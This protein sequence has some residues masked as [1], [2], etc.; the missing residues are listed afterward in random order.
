MFK[1][2]GRY[3]VRK[4][5]MFGMFTFC[6]ALG[7]AALVSVFGN[8]VGHS[9]AVRHL[10]FSGCALPAHISNRTSADSNIPDNSGIFQ[11]NFG[12]ENPEDLVVREAK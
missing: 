10:G 12:I 7:G 3:A 8:K 2:P 4:T 9:V 6:L 5:A 11:D 1:S